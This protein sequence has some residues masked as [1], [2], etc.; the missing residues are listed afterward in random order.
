MCNQK[1]RG[2]ESLRLVYVIRNE[3]LRLAFPA[4]VPSFFQGGGSNKTAHAY[5]LSPG[6][7]CDFL[8]LLF[9]VVRNDS[10]PYDS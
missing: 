10:F 8:L 6:C 7:L 1:R 9:G 4:S 3:L 5:P 2:A